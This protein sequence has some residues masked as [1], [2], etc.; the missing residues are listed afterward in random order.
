MAL[1]T[2]FDNPKSGLGSREWHVVG[3]DRLGEA[4]EG[5]RA[6]LFG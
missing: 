3:H 1:W 2:T 4:L 6:N 5:E